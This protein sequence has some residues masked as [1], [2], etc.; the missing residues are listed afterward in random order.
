MEGKKKKIFSILHNVTLRYQVMFDTLFPIRG[1]GNL[2]GEIMKKLCI[3][4]K[5]YL[6]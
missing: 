4:Q 6:L 5:V 1:A 3:E 2:N